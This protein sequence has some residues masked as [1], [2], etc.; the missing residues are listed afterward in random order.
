MS[1]TSIQTRTFV[2]WLIALSLLSGTA[3]FA[4]TGAPPLSKLTSV[5][6]IASVHQFLLPGTD[7]P[8][9]LKAD[10]GGRSNLPIRYAVPQPVELTPETSGT[11]ESVTG[12][13]LWRLRITS[14][15]A[16]D[17]N[18]AFTT[19]WLPPGATLYVNSENEDY[20][21]GPYTAQDNSAAAQLWTPVVP[22][23][24]AVVEL[25]VPD[26]T[27]DQPR[28]VLTQVGTGYRDLFHQKSGSDAKAGTCNIDVVCPQGL[29]WTNE[30]RSV[31]RYSI[32]GTYLCTGTL[33]AD[34]AG[35]F[36]NFFLTA[37]HCELSSANAA[38][39]VVY[40]NFQSP[41][42]GEH[43]GG[44]LAQ[45]QSGAI[46]RAA[47]TDVDFA[48][49]EL[50]ATPDPSYNVYY[51][52]WDRSGL[53][54][55][56]CVGIHHP[57]ADEKSISFATGTLTTVNSCIGSGGS[58]THWRVIWTS[59]VT[60]EGSSGSG[61]WDPNTHRLVGTLSGGG[62][63][64]STPSSADCYGKF[65]VSWASGK[66][67]ADR[68]M[69]WLD[70]LNTGATSVPGMD[71]AQTVAIA[72][73]GTSLA[74]ETCLPTNGVVDPGETVTLNF[75]LRNMAAMNSTN[76]VATLLATN[77]VV[78]PS[79]PQT[80][81][82]LIGRGASVSKPFTFT[83]NA[84]CG[85]TIA[86]V[87]QLQDGTIDLG[88]VTFVISLGTPFTT[89][90]FTENFDGV[91]AP[92]KPAGWTS[93][94][95]GSGTAWA[96]STNQRDT[97]PNSL[98]AAD[99]SGVTDNMLLSPMIVIGTSNAK[100]S[101]RHNYNTESGYDGGALEIS[102]NGG[103]FADILAAGGSFATNGYNQTL[104]TSYSNPLG[105]RTAWSGSS[106]GFITTIVNLPSGLPGRTMQFRWRL[107]SDTSIS[108]TGWYVDTV[109]VSQIGFS[110]CFPPPLIVDTRPASGDNMAFSFDT[111]TGL[112]Y[113][114]Q[115]RTNLLTTNWTTL[116]T[117][118]GDGTRKSFTNS[119]PGMTEGEF[120]L[121]TQ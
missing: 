55:V 98:F 46:F 15:G 81:G 57:N 11:W 74:S 58:S 42:C 106:G 12:G 104:S 101:F 88:T 96:T 41:T 56:G 52:G 86:P 33:I 23:D 20:Y 94:I 116:C 99:P 1:S 107:G 53:A 65:S 13:R 62:S 112:N 111:V 64:C 9:Q 39:V 117:N 71:P 95:T 8:A 75:S 4:K 76:L 7:R 31:A 34:V 32:S 91:T 43:G 16:T 118:A 24:A 6:P 10:I 18:L 61:I 40:W 70:P 48:L 84:P 87:L 68:L 113:L 38:S 44:S 19:F 78:L 3:L 72:A 92:S 79:G 85:A 73:V 50:V 59:G 28:L 69:D 82:V 63:S 22:G 120:R 97:A 30:I 93:T 25:F 27:K 102:I 77:G 100:L 103:G 60:E 115:A 83:A 2:A 110:C 89:S 47:K 17:L 21:Q 121:R 80:Y 54:P 26:S 49:I 108:S 37:N 66:S 14:P 5:L 109:S 29:P 90:A 35:D 119:T 36:R 51:A 67:S 105:G 114:V 45:N